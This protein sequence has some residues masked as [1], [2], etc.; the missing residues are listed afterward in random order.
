M[1][2]AHVLHAASKLGPPGVQVGD[3]GS[4]ISF[5]YRCSNRCCAHK[6]RTSYFVGG[7][8]SSEPTGCVI[9]RLLL[10]LL[11]GWRCAP[12]SEPENSP[13]DFAKQMARQ[14]RTT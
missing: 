12:T 10:S 8:D 6:S 9:P 11:R 13:S 3:R 5:N 1:A 4:Q 7:S 2:D 14:T